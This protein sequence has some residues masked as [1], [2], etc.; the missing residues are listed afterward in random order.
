MAYIY[1]YYGDQGAWW[2]EGPLKHLGD[3][4]PWCTTGARIW[5]PRSVSKSHN[6]AWNTSIP[7]WFKLYT[8]ILYT[9]LCEV[10]R[11]ETRMHAQHE[12]PKELL[13]CSDPDEGNVFEKI[14][15]KKKS[16]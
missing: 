12:A 8:G 10:K 5:V 14:F 11:R 7:Y 6:V 4:L 15:D 16:L 13:V 2:V 3:I 9:H 1:I